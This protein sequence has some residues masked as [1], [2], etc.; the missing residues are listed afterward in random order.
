MHIVFT[1]LHVRAFDVQIFYFQPVLEGV[2]HDRDICMWK[3][4]EA[5]L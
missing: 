1:V 2:F 3:N 4:G 5:F